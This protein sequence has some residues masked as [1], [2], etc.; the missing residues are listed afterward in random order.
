MLGVFQFK[1]VSE[2]FVAMFEIGV[3]GYLPICAS[4]GVIFVIPCGFMCNVLIISTTSEANLNG[5]LFVSILITPSRRVCIN[6]STTP[7]DL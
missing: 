5:V 7:M 2:L 4:H 1:L 3:L 6:L